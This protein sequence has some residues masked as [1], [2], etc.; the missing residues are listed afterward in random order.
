M[1]AETPI[2]GV[3]HYADL[4]AEITF[5][6]DLT[7]APIPSFCGGGREGDQMTFDD[8]AV[9]CPACLAQLATP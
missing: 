7:I 6:D 4:A 1:S 3:T 9:T 5:F 2:R 8:A